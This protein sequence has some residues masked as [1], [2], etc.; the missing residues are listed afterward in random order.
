[1]QTKFLPNSHNTPLK[2]ALHSCRNLDRKIINK[3]IRQFTPFL[4]SYGQFINSEENRNK[5]IN[6]ANKIENK[7]QKT[8]LKMHYM[9]FLLIMLIV[10]ILLMII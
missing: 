9:V 1:M 3:S 10:S 6:I 5:I 8:I 2:Y 4:N 7:Q